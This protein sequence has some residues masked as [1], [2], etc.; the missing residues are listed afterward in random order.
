MTTRA[1][2]AAVRTLRRQTPRHLRD[3]VLSA[4]LIAETGATYR[5]VDYWTRT[6]LLT[7]IDGVHP[8]EGHDRRYAAD[9]LDRCRAVVALLAAGVSLEAVR[10]HLDHLIQHGGYQTGAVTITYTP[11]LTQ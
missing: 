6:G 11:E 9:Q 7:P 2:G 10:T 3:W 1:R 4:E 5:Q 8:G